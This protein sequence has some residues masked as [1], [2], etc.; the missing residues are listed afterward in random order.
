[1]DADTFRLIL[2]VAGGLLLVGLFVWEQRRARHGEDEL[3]EDEDLDE[4]KREPRLG[5]W[6]GD[7]DDA[8]HGD[9]DGET[10]RG[11]NWNESRL[12]Q[13]PKPHLEPP[14]SRPAVKAREGPESPMIL[15]L[16]LT[17]REGTF[18]GEAIVHAAGRCGIEPGEMDLFHRFSDDPHSSNRP[19]FSVANM[20]KPGTFPFGAM[21]EFESPGL[22]LFFQAEG[23][24]DDPLRFD[25]M[26]STA[27]CLAD[28]LDAEV[29]DGTRAMLT[30]EVEADLRDRVLELVIWRLSDTGKE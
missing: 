1:M 23:A 18:E 28:E 3:G 13:G 24:S 17:P 15:S 14:A 25:L 16:H 27:R 9:G 11:S 19:L 2:I 26:L 29:R 20:V 4:D 8:G 22:T 21:A 6:H 5:A 30:P 7:G 10:A 12:S